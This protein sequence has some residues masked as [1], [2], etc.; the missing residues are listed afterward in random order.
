MRKIKNAFTSL[1]IHHKTILLIGFLM[2]IS[3]TFYVSVLGYVFRIYDRQIYE[4]SS[5]VLNMSSVGI[6]NQ[7]R[8]IANLSFKVMSDE[9]LQQYLLQLDKAE[10]GYEKMGC[11]KDNQ[12]TCRVCRIREVHLFHDIYR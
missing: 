3:F 8:E 2:L 10:S 6:E 11:S 7:L 1:P 4:K 12:P 9:A 5:Q